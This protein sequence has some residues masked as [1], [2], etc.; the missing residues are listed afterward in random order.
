MLQNEAFTAWM[1]G[2]GYPLKTPTYY[3]RD[4]ERVE[5][6]LGIVMEPVSVAN[7]TQILNSIGNEGPARTPEQIRNDQSAVNCYHEYR[8]GIP[9]P[10]YC[11]SGPRR[12]RA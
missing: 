8:T 6:R 7:T 9:L 2:Q 3:L 11:R 12:R 5:Q 4:T 10:G 1:T